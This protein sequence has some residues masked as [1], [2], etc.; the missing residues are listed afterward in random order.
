VATAILPPTIVLNA[1][2]KGYLP[3]FFSAT[4]SNSSSNNRIKKIRFKKTGFLSLTELSPNYL[5]GAVAG[6]GITDI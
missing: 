2:G 1:I 5:I 3:K 6:I 4:K